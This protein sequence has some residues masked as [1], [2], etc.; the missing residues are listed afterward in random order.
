[1]DAIFLK[2]RTPNPVA[3]LFIKELRAVAKPLLH[4][5]DQP[6]RKRT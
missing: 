6:A 4:R 3:R 2:N 5:A 1:V